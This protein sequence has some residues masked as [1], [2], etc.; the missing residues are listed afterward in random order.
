MTILLEQ[1]RKFSPESL[2]FLEIQDERDLL[3]AERIYSRGVPILKCGITYIQGDFNTTTDSGKFVPREELLN[4]GYTNSIDGIW[5]LKG[6]PDA[7]PLYEGHM[8]GLLQ[9]SKKGYVSGRA[10]A[11]KWRIISRDES[12][13]EPQYLVMENDS[14]LLGTLGKPGVSFINVTSSTNTRTTI[15]TLSPPFPH[16]HSTPRFLIEFFHQRLPEIFLRAGRKRCPIW[17]QLSLS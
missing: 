11:A 15:V 1:I 12:V 14:R 5:R 16:N 3:I 8:V 2:S 6:S 9:F 10:R 17:T 13:L 7:L 4:K